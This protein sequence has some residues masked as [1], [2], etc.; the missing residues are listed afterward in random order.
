MFNKAD[1]VGE[2]PRTEVDEH[3]GV[4]RV[5]MSAATGEG[6]ALLIDA[7]AQFLHPQEQW[8]DTQFS[9]DGHPHLKWVEVKAPDIS[10]YGSLLAGGVR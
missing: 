10:Q 3:G 8:K 7:I 2:A 1:L 6:A 5:W 4:R 9:L